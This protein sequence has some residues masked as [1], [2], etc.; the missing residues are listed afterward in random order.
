MNLSNEGKTLLKNL[1]CIGGKP[2]LVPYKDGGGV[3][4]WGFGHARGPHESVPKSIT[5]EEADALLENDAG[6]AVKDV[7]AMLGYDAV[8]QNVF[9]ALVIFLYN[10]GITALRKPPHRTLNAILAREWR[11]AAERMRGWCHDRDPKTG[12]MIKV[13]GLKNRR[14]REIRLLLK[15]GY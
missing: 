9:D 15:G 3:W 4:T 11:L 5:T 2:N 6:W 10:I 1:E 12:K 13:E 7:N 8:P 14:E